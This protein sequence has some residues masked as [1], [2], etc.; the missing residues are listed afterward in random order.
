MGHRL[1]LHV[2]VCV[3]VQAWHLGE[4]QRMVELQESACILQDLAHPRTADS[5]HSDLR[6]RLDFSAD[7]V[8]YLLHL[9]RAR[10]KASALQPHG[11]LDASLI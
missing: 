6:V 2:C 9:G 11:Q 10:I 3:C 8:M 5:L 7:E 1:L 4:F